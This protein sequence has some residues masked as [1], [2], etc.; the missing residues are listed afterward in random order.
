M[1][2]NLDLNP[3]VNKICKVNN[4]NIGEE[5]K[6]NFSNYTPGGS[7]IISNFLD[8]FAEDSFVT[9]FLGGLNGERYHNMLSDR[10]LA[11]EFVPI[12]D[13]TKLKL[14]IIDME[15]KQMVITDEEPRVTREETKKLLNLYLNSIEDSEVICGSSVTLPLGLRDEIYY[16]LINIS[17]Q[18]G[19]KFILTAQG[20]ELKKGI[21]AIPYMTIL[22]KSNL[23]DLTMLELQYENEIIRASNYILHRGIEFVVIS[24]DNNEI[25]LLG[26]KKGYRVSSDIVTKDRGN[27]DLRKISAAFALGINRNY[28]LDMTLRLAYAFN[29]Y[30][31]SDN[32][33]EIEISKIKRMMTKVEI[34][35]IN[36]F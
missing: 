22:N 29:N 34:Y 4:V 5:I 15:G 6:S 17:N 25:L 36:Y 9:G 26:Q 11:H 33:S 31:I 2:L 3:Y 14:K 1:I 13:E 21:D 27:N 30:E 23:E 28:D 16:E 10:N 12:K 35:S 8:A 7:I 18:S 19:K 24:L 20:Q 32:S